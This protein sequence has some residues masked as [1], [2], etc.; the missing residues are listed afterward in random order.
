MLSNE[1][2]KTII[3]EQVDKE[4]NA[5]WK[6]FSDYELF[7]PISYWYFT[8]NGVK[9]DSKKAYEILDEIIRD[10]SKNKQGED[11]CRYYFELGNIW[12]VLNKLEKAKEYYEK[13]LQYSNESRYSRYNSILSGSECKKCLKQLH[14]KKKSTEDDISIAHLHSLAINGSSLAQLK[15]AIFYFNLFQNSKDGRSSIECKAQSSAWFRKLANKGDLEAQC[16]LGLCYFDYKEFPPAFNDE[17]Y[18]W[19]KKAAEGGNRDAQFF[20]ANMLQ[21]DYRRSNSKN[22]NKGK[23]SVFRECL[24]NYVNA[25]ENRNVMAIKVLAAPWEIERDVESQE[26]LSQI[27]RINNKDSRNFLEN[28][29]AIYELLSRAKKFKNLQYSYK[30]CA[31]EGDIASQYELLKILYNERLRNNKDNLDSDLQKVIK[32]ISENPK[33]NILEA[34]PYGFGLDP[35]FSE[36]CGWVAYE[37]KDYDTALD[38]LLNALKLKSTN[39][40]IDINSRTYAYLGNMYFYG[41]GTEKDEM[42]A[43]DY[44]KK[45]RSSSSYDIGDE[46]YNTYNKI[47]QKNKKNEGCFITS[48]VCNSFGRNDDCYELTLF[49]NYRD[50]WLLQQND[51]LALIKRYYA[52]APSIV[53]AID[54]KPNSANIYL[55]I[56]KKFLYPCICFIEAGEF[57][58]CKTMYISMV[59]KLENIYLKKEEK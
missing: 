48:A 23:W 4:I 41:K 33:R 35:L 40:T 15:L 51:G 5:E 57:E 55:T 6:R 47:Q 18:K 10:N 49:R 30:I 25:A 7:F 29:Q 9:K 2:I 43:T 19:F 52:I 16:Y 1:L 26:S 14:D 44:Y 28:K 46:A 50:N 58:D 27:S 54:E 21:Y 53:K 45:M 31:Q 13:S 34:W 17:A 24:Q 3:N 8:G 20:L 32:M 56:W 42:A 36:I 59:K 22:N 37:N 38:A 39:S 11:F 12:F